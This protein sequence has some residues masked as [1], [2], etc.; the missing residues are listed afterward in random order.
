MFVLRVGC[1]SSRLRSCFLVNSQRSHT[2]AV[3]QQENSDDK[4]RKRQRKAKVQPL[5]ELAPA[6]LLDDSA[7]HKFLAHLKDSTDTV[8]I[9]EFEERYRPKK[10]LLP[11]YS[12]Y[13]QSYKA[14][15]E[16]IAD[17]FNLKQLQH[18]IQLYGLEPP[19]FRQKWNYATA[20][21][22]QAWGYP[23]LHAVDI[24][25]QDRTVQVTQSKQLYLYFVQV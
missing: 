17:A 12:E 10:P 24:E 4:P 13:E 25:K 5:D 9:E 18:I 15:Q 2:S 21:I 11:E 6:T 16:N 20:I 8:S 1:R 22:E 7:V 3:I 14:L 19:Q 23:S